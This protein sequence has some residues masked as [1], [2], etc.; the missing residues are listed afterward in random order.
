MS[1]VRVPDPPPNSS[2]VRTLIRIFIAAVLIAFSLG[3]AQAQVVR[4]PVPDDALQGKIT[5][6]TASQIEIDGKPFHLAPGTRILNQRNLTVTPN[7][8]AAGTPA[9]YTLDASGQVR[10]IWLVDT[11]APAVAAPVQRTTPG[12]N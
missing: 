3:A 9:R 11:N 10:A 6:A 12:T 2:S 8:V 7:M 5:A 1:G 4:R